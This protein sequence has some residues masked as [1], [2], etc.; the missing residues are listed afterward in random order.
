MH[1]ARILMVALLVTGLTACETDQR[2]QKEVGGALLGAI[3]RIARQS[4]L[5][6]TDRNERQQRSEVGPKY[7]F[8][9]Y[10]GCW[11]DASA[12]ASAI[13]INMAKTRR[14]FM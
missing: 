12:A 5:E 4:H 13:P 1:I 10:S 7:F 6:L 2:G 14:R 8:F 11:A 3:D 9:L